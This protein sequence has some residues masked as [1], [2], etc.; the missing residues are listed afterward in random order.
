MQQQHLRF[1][2]NCQL[3]NNFL[4]QFNKSNF[5]STSTAQQQFTTFSTSIFPSTTTVQQL[6]TKEQQHH[7]SFNRNCDNN[8]KFR[9]TITAQQLLKFSPQCNKSIFPSTATVQQQCTHLA[10]EFSNNCATTVHDR[11]T[12]LPFLQQKL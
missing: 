1:N 6:I 10:P 3:R 2:S 4:R 5:P 12:T 11:A 7:L 8:S 9:S